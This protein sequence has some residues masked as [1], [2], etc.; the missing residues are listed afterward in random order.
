MSG[1]SGSSELLENAAQ[2]QADPARHCCAPRGVLQLSRGTHRPVDSP[3]GNRINVESQKETG[4]HAFIREEPQLHLAQSG[5][6]G[7][8]RATE[9]GT[10]AELSRGSRDPRKP[11]SSAMQQDTRSRHA[12]SG[13]LRDASSGLSHLLV[14]ALCPWPVSS[15]K[16]WDSPRP[17]R[18]PLHTRE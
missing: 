18:P 9:G 12:M 3:T 7:T 13:R 17:Q 14:L 2:E 16:L 6:W 5:L 8:V 11:R 4:N 1:C 15:G 10:R